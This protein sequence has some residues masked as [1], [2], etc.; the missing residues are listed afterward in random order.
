[1]G[2][3]DFIKKFSRKEPEI[4]VNEKVEFSNIKYFLENKKQQLKLQ[5]EEFLNKFKEINNNLISSLQEKIKQLE[6]LDLDQKK[7]EDRIKIIVKEN[8]KSYLYYVE[9]LIKDISNLE[10][11]NSSLDM[12]SKINSTFLNFQKKAETSYQKATYLIGELGQIKEEISNY[13]KKTET[14]IKENDDI[15]KISKILKSIEKKLEE[16]LK[17]DNTSEEI[18]KEKSKNEEKINEVNNKIINHEEEIIKIKNSNEH[19]E[20]LKNEETLNKKDGELEIQIIKIKNLINLKTLSGICHKS[21]KDMIIIKNYRNNFINAF[22]EDSNNKLKEIL[23]ST[24]QIENKELIG[25]QL[26]NIENLN[27]E[28]EM[29]NNSINNHSLKEIQRINE[30]IRNTKSELD[31][32]NRNIEKENKRLV[33]SR[34][35]KDLTLDLI[36]NILEDINVEL[37]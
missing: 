24:N 1:M 7:A 9:L 32:L 28:I 3:F 22:K 2:I 27:G 29:I 5:E 34:K 26:I 16:L 14:L 11:I 18:D 30:Q 19:K 8:F 31:N 13:F 15:I 37:V 36:K 21:E 12:I 6:N 10:E 4:V 17:I 20:L 23:D 33:K 35:N 25:E